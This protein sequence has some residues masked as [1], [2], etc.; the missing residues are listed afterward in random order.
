MKNGFLPSF[1]LYNLSMI[2]LNFDYNLKKD[3]WSWVLIAKSKN[4]FGLNWRKQNAQIPNDLLAKIEKATFAGAQKIVEDY[5]EK[6][7]KKEYKN[8]V[9]DYEMMAL[10]RSWHLVEKKYFKTLANITQKPI[11]A[12]K[13][14]C[15]FT[16]GLMCPYNEKENWF[17]VSMWHSIPFSITTI[18]HE[19]MHL[20]F[21]HYYRNYLKK[22]GLTNDQIEDLKESLTVLLNES[23]FDSIILSQDDGYPEHNKLRKKLAGVWLKNKDFQ[24]LLDE[25]VHF[26][27]K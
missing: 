20:Q 19:I 5:I 12:D 10:E 14:D 8:R 21:L 11:F 17:M 3:A 16:T 26:I 2:K 4:I 7:A 27:G 22:K 6:G 25:A 1:S 9:M 15:Y 23:E 13:F 24:N 18:C